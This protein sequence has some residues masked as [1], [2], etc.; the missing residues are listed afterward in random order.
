[1]ESECE[2]EIG[3]EGEEKLEISQLKKANTVLGE[4]VNDLTDQMKLCQKNH[5]SSKKPT[6]Q[7][8]LTSKGFLGVGSIPPPL[9]GANY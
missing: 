7:I 5:E 2:G 1:M 3:S 8:L 4:K 6:Q 9:P